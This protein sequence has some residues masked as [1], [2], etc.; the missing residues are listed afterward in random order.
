MMP[1]ISIIVPAYNEASRL[2][3]S[4]RAILGYLRNHGTTELIVV[5]DGSQD[6]TVEVALESIRGLSPHRAR[7]IRCAVN[8]GKGFAVRAGLMAAR[9]PIALFTD[10]DLSTPVTEIP[11]ITERIARG[12]CDVTFG[13]R[14]VDRSLIGVHQPGDSGS[15]RHGS[16]RGTRAE[17]RVSRD[18]AGNLARQSAQR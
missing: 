2:A 11:K 12:E 13:S 18:R 7:V 16:A 3:T 6:G 8:R 15:K 14:A 9:A 1:D 17:Y 5:D 10:A 4:L